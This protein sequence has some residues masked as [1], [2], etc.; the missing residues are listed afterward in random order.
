MEILNTVHFFAPSLYLMAIIQRRQREKENI[1]SRILEEARLLFFEKGYD[2]AS[3]RNI[4]ERIEYSVGTIYLHFKDKD[5]I[6]HALK[7]EGFGLLMAKMQV[8]ESVEHPFER[9]KAMGTIYLD[10]AKK[11]SE[12]YDLMFIL[13][14]PMNCLEE[15]EGWLEGKKTFDFL[16]KIVKECQ[17]IGQFRNHADAETL[18]FSIWSSVHGIAALIVRDRCRVVSEEKRETID[19]K[20]YRDYITM[21]SKS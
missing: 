21:L 9:L 19:V 14:A 10:F 15:H 2:N 16:I 7:L 17:E 13:R 4:A 20:A 3:I 11:N 5:S 18:A 12:L 8:L 6:F 1:R